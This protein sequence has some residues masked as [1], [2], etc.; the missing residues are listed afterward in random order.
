MIAALQKVKSTCI[1]QASILQLHIQAK[2]KHNISEYNQKVWDNMLTLHSCTMGAQNSQAFDKNLESLMTL[3]RWPL[4]SRDRAIAP[5]PQAFKAAVEQAFRTLAL[6]Y[7]N[8]QAYQD[9]I[10]SAVGHIWRTQH[11][12]CPP[13]KAF[14]AVT[15]SLHNKIRTNSDSLTQEERILTLKQVDANYAEARR[16][17]WMLCLQAYSVSPHR[18]VRQK[19]S[20]ILSRV[21]WLTSAQIF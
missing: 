12:G 7:N 20:A 8:L 4:G 2:E 15:A 18:R 16:D 1:E 11:Q 6:K 13:E 3:A 19:Q 17:L 10:E 9:V 21:L 14:A 5:A